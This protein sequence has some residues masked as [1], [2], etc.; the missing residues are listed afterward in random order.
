VSRIRLSETES[1]ADEQREGSCFVGTAFTESSDLPDG[2]G[3]SGAPATTA[4]ARPQ[5]CSARSKAPVFVL[6]C[7]RSGTTLLYHMLLSAGG[8]AVLR[9]ETHAFS[10]L[11]AAY[12]DLRVVRN[13]E[14]LA[15]AWLKTR[16]FRISGLDKD[17]LRARIMAECSNGG[18]FLR[19]FM[20][21]IARKQGV[22]RWAECTPDHLLYIARIKQTVP[23]ALIVHIIRDGRDVA[24]SLDKQKWIRPL[25][26]DAAKH[27]EVAALYWEWIVARGRE[28]GHK[29][30]EDYCEVR[31]EELVGD[32]R[33]VLKRL[34]G[35]I[36]QDLNYDRIREVAIGSVAEPNTSFPKSKPVDVFNPVGRWKE[37]LPERQLRR[38]EALMGGALRELGYAAGE[39]EAPQPALK[40][41]RV[42]YRAYFDLKL[43]MKNQTPLGKYLVNK[44]LDWL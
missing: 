7:A 23:E 13:R 14:R 35:F 28:A 39:P 2:A 38:I 31:F 1:T 8:F 21:E 12:G 20:G 33:P 24:L 22:E 36:E 43:W 5:R 11:E 17:E 26:G 34:S 32:P 4:E 42:R 9:S 15:D 10:V 40:W 18:S 30:G 6:G 29:L 19:I 44:N 3:Q 41:L 37:A 25:P 16:V 27:L